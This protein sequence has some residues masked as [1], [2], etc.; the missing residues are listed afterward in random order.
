MVVA[1]IGILAALALAQALFGCVQSVPPASPQSPAPEA[2]QQAAR[3]LGFIVL[4]T[5]ELEPQPDGSAAYPILVQWGNDGA[6]HL[7]CRTD[8]A[9]GVTLG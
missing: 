4:G 6:V 5:G 8:G 1:R 3:K 7:R 9:A 2:C